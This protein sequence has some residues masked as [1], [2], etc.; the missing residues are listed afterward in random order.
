MKEGSLE[1]LDD[2]MWIE[3]DGSVNGGC[4]K[5]PDEQHHSIYD[6]DES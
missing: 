1:P 5:T 6:P 2:R 4:D 3:R